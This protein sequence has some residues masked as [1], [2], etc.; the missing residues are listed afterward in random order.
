M[1]EQSQDDLRFAQALREELEA[2]VANLD[3]LTLARLRTARQHAVAQAQPAPV[4]T[5]W[6]LTAG[7]LGL[8]AAIALAWTLTAQMPGVPPTLSEVWELAY[9]DEE[10]LELYEDL[11]FYEWLEEAETETPPRPANKSLTRKRSSPPATGSANDLA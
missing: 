8:A 1:S 9:F 7:G 10:A 11:E 4:R 6:W 3:E 5:R 2:S